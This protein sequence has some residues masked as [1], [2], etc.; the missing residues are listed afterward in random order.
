MPNPKISLE[1][2]GT[3][4][5]FNHAV[6][7]DNF[8][9]KDENY[10][11]F[12]KKIKKW[13]LPIADIFAYCLMPNHFHFVVRIKSS[14]LLNELWVEKLKKRNRVSKT[15]TTGASHNQILLLNDLITEQFSHCFNSYAQS[16]NKT[17]NRKGSLF[18]Q[19]FQ[20]KRIDTNEYLCQAICYTHNNPISHGFVEKRDAWKYS[21]YVAI[22]GNKPTLVLRTE[23]LELFGG[24]ENLIYVHEK[25]LGDEI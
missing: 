17:Y 12:L 1:P 7:N 21:S 22:I 24:L 13:V 25:Y 3:Y 20:R 18:K 11:F 14:N 4:H 8:F 10:F 15:D 9:R 2:D 6:G 5:V 19:S 16:Y 23:V